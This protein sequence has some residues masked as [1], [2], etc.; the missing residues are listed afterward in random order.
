M[1]KTPS[2]MYAIAI[3]IVLHIGVQ[4]H[5]RYMQIIAHI[6]RVVA[7]LR[8]VCKSQL[9]IFLNCTCETCVLGLLLRCVLVNYGLAN[10]NIVR[11]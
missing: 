6:I 9:P 2:L 1:T 5:G 11:I 10:R 7:A 4:W 8:I 3:G